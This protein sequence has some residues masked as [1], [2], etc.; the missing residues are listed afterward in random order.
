MI[1]FA[2]VAVAFNMANRNLTKKGPVKKRK[3]Y[4]EALK[5]WE[6]FKKQHP[7]SGKQS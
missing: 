3:T 1:G 6:E 2:L 4:R 5:D 7:G